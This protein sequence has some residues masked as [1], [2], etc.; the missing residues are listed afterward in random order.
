[1]PHCDSVMS[2]YYIF[3]IL[4][5]FALSGCR[6]QERIKVEASNRGNFF[7]VRPWTFTLDASKTK[8]GKLTIMGKTIAIRFKV[9]ES[10]IKKLIK[11]IQKE[12]FFSLPDTIGGRV[13]CGSENLLKISIN[14]KTKTVNVYYLL[15]IKKQEKI[16]EAKRVVRILILVRDMIENPLAVDHRKWYRRYLRR[17]PVC[18]GKK[19]SEWVKQLKYKDEKKRNKAVEALG[20][21]N[22][23]TAIHIL[24]KALE[25]EDKFFRYRICMALGKIGKPAVPLLIKALKS[26][27][28]NVC[29]SAVEALGMIRDKAVGPAL[30]KALKDKAISPL[31]LFA[32][33]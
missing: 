10:K 29:T 17:K 25:D 3:L 23:K 33:T 28:E 4:F 24:I 30:I 18:K 22:N 9:S 26:K 31:V 21:I 1:M 27:N 16:E 19:L 7:K 32:L 8:S 5:V 12:D 6:N 20:S 2:K 14:G 11:S 15:N 13:P